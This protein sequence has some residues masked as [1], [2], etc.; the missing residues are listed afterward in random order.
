MIVR[1]LAGTFR[2]ATRSVS[3]SSFDVR[4]CRRARSSR[5]A[6]GRSSTPAS[7][8]GDGVAPNPAGVLGA[9]PTGPGSITVARRSSRPPVRS[10]TPGEPPTAVALKPSTLA[11]EAA[12]HRCSGTPALRRRPDRPSAGMTLV[13]VPSAGSSRGAGLRRGVDA[14][15]HSQRLCLRGLGV[16]GVQVR[17]H[18]C[19]GQGSVLGDAGRAGPPRPCASSTSPSAPEAHLIWPVPRL[20]EPTTKAL[21][22]VGSG[23]WSSSVASAVWP[24]G[25]V[26]CA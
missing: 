6:S 22:S 11:T 16:P 14:S 15:S 9:A 20:D 17:P 24:G 18:D 8:S 7:S 19:P 21:M 23:C 4:G 13:G 3:D 26:A 25:G 10:E 12:R 2:V 5:T 1:K